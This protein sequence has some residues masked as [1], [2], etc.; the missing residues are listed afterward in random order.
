MQE[1][2]HIH[3]I[4]SYNLNNAADNDPDFLQNV[5]TGED[6]S[7]LLCDLQSKCPSSICKSPWLPRATKFWQDHSNGKVM[8]EVLF[9]L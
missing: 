9:N 4:I 8:L 3:M 6:T 5:I 2:S 7:C 1:Q